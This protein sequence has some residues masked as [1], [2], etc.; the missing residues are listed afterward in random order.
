MGKGY[1]DENQTF[2]IYANITLSL[3]KKDMVYGWGWGGK[4]VILSPVTKYAIVL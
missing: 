2:L 4:G 3:E 1:L